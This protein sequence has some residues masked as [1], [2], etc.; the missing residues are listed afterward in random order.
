MTKET[1]PTQ[2]SNITEA[3]SNTGT[4]EL[5]QIAEEGLEDGQRTYEL[6][7]EIMELFEDRLKTGKITPLELSEALA[8]SATSSVMSMLP[9]ESREEATR[10][11][12]K[13]VED[14]MKNYEQ[15]TRK[16]KNYFYIS[17]LLAPVRF[18]TY[19]LTQGKTTYESAVRKA[20]SAAATEE[21]DKA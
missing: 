15:K 13:L 2:E 16:R 4:E 18:A 19:I 11:S 9:P 3:Q 8:L 14:I 10:Q 7:K 12:D 5:V 6:V 17:Q 21:A 20:T 1:N